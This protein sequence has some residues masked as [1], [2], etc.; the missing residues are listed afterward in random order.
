MNAIKKNVV[1]LIYADCN[2]KAG[3][4]TFFFHIQTDVGLYSDTKI[5]LFKL[6]HVK[7]IKIRIKILNINEFLFTPQRKI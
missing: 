3:V 2:I 4:S 6:K 7:S 1:V 5:K